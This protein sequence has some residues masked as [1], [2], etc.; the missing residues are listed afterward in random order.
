VP[1]HK[2]GA[3][4]GFDSVSEAQNHYKRCR[5]R[6]HFILSDSAAADLECSC[7]HALIKDGPQGK[8]PDPGYSGNRCE[9]SP[10]RKQVR[11]MHYL[12]AWGNVM[13]AVYR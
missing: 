13:S 2:H 8:A 3:Y 9:Y 10:S 11:I 12:C 4:D 1:Y 7:C 5:T 6:K